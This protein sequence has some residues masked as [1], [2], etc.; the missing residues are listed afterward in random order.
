M[1][2]KPIVVHVEGDGGGYSDGNPDR[3]AFRYFLQAHCDCEVIPYNDEYDLD[4]A[5]GKIKSYINHGAV[6]LVVINQDRYS[7]QHLRAIATV[8]EL[9]VDLSI[10]VIPSWRSDEKFEGDPN[11]N[12]IYIYQHHSDKE[13]IG[14]IRQLASAWQAPLDW[15]GAE[16]DA[17]RAILMGHLENAY[18]THY[19][20]D[21]SLRILGTPDHNHQVVAQ[22]LRIKILPAN[23]IKTEFDDTIP[24][25]DHAFAAVNASVYQQE[26]ERIRNM[27]D[28]ERTKLDHKLQRARGHE[29]TEGGGVYVTRVS[30][31]EGVAGLA[32]D[33]ETLEYLVT[34]RHG[35]HHMAKDLLAP[36]IQAIDAMKLSKRE[37]ELTQEE[38][39]APKRRI[40]K[41][42]VFSKIQGFTTPIVCIWNN[43]HSGKEGVKRVAAFLMQQQKFIPVNTDTKIFGDL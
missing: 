29:P 22:A 28:D 33:P 21:D 26:V 14:F 13:L 25:I 10:V 40:M 38:E 34:T 24:A 2:R 41:G 39:W 4:R 12:Q 11:D 32:I 15:L 35:E 9:S 3:D 31:G 20:S 19:L 37:I 5:K 6:I 1:A 8:R 17:D 42:L 7:E 27:D 36:R 43:F 23:L 30:C 16:T 18:Q